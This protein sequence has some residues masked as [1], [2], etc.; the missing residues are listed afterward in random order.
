[1]TRRITDLQV[2]LP[3]GEVRVFIPDNEKFLAGVRDSPVLEG[4]GGGY[5]LLGKILI[6]AGILLALFIVSMTVYTLA[7]APKEMAWFPCLFTIA[8]GL[9]MS[10]FGKYTL[11]YGRRMERLRKEATHVLPGEVVNSLPG[12][13]GSTTLI[14]RAH[15][16]GSG[17]AFGG[18]LMVG[19][20]SPR[21]GRLVPGCRVAILYLDPKTHALL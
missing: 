6:P 13:H 18:S 16:P 21:R 9:G 4:T 14:W 11:D 19:K 1:M 7:T 10:W 15:A 20:L 5:A 12:P 17:Q 3:D 2:Q 8:A